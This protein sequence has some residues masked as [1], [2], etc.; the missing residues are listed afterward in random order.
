M[1][2][3]DPAVVPPVL[4][5]L[6]KASI[7]WGQ[8]RR[9]ALNIRAQRSSHRCEVADHGDMSVGD[10]GTPACY[11]GDIPENA[12]EWCE[13][14]QRRQLLHGQ[15]VAKDAEQKRLRARFLRLL[16]KSLAS[17]LAGLSSLKTNGCVKCG[18]QQI[19]GATMDTVPL[20]RA[21][22]ESFKERMRQ[23]FADDGLSSLKNEKEHEAARVDEQTV[24]PPERATASE[25]EA[26]PT[27]PDCGAGIMFEHYVGCRRV[28]SP[29]SDRNL[30]WL[31]DIEA[32]ID[33]TVPY[34][35]PRLIAEIRHLERVLAL[36]RNPR[37]G[38]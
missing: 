4:E 34:Y 19:V 13:S 8:A 23:V 10:M 3:D 7:A 1:A 33:G 30:K 36:M 28:P 9:E 37:M 21:C 12:A 18:E 32:Q 22:Y 2:A 20:C 27:C 6:A 24:I 15:Y 25:N 11:L 5:Q 14:C 16:D 26:I 31:D 17:A 38:L 35:V 29:T